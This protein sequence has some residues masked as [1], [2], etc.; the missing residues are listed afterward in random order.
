[1]A[2]PVMAIPIIAHPALPPRYSY[3]ERVGVGG[4]DA[5]HAMTKLNFPRI[6]HQV[7]RY[8]STDRKS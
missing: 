5:S 2:A 6:V 7:A 3:P 1:M 4:A 8:K